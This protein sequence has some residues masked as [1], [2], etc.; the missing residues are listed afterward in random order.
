MKSLDQTRKPTEFWNCFLSQAMVYGN[1]EKA[2][3]HKA[4][5]YYNYNSGRKSKT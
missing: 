3:M 1:F 5:L 4:H 2:S